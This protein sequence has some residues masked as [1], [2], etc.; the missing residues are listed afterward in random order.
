MSGGAYRARRAREATAGRESSPQRRLGPRRVNG[1]GVLPPG[2]APP[3]LGRRASPQNEMEAGIA[4]GLHCPWFH[5]SCPKARPPFPGRFR[6]RPRGPGRSL[7]FLRGIIADPVPV[8]AGSAPRLAA[9]FG[10]LAGTFLLGLA[11]S[12]SG[13]LSVVREASFAVVLS[14][15]RPPGGFR[16]RRTL[17]GKWVRPW[18]AP[19]P[20]ASSFRLPGPCFVQP[21]ILANF[22][23]SPP[24]RAWERLFRFRK[25]APR[26][27]TDNGT[28][29]RVGQARNGRSDLWITGI[30]G[31]NMDQFRPAGATWLLASRLR[32]RH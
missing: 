1:A 26:H 21:E 6:P 15:F 31:I 29:R 14:R 19:P 22:R 13:S 23:R 11:A 9:G 27:R 5:R 10:S 7:R 18:L 20:R 3:S 2:G 12:I 4:A 8:P 32:A 24:G 16:F 17:E 30:S 25:A 28:R